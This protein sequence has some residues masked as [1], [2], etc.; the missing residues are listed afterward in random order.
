MNC[1]LGKADSVAAWLNWIAAIQLAL[2]QLFQAQADARNVK[3]KSLQKAGISDSAIRCL[4][5]Q[6]L[7]EDVAEKN[8]PRTSSRA[9][10]NHNGPSLPATSRFVLTDKGV[11]FCREMADFKNIVP[12]PGK[13]PHFGPVPGSDKSC[14]QLLYNDVVVKEY[15]QLARNQE[16]I[17]TSFQELG[18]PLHID[19]PL[20][21]DAGHDAR[22]RLHNAVKR[23]NLQRARVLCFKLDGQGRGVFWAPI[24]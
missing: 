10:C 3:M 7:L 1:T 12:A 5:C 6:G 22:D 16:L 19:D 18:W 9:R 24:P 20:P 15:F 4:V 2:A 14:R 17:L 8:R 13:L 11:A 21:R 23:L